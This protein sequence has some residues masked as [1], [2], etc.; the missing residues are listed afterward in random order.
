MNPTPVT[1]SSG[2]PAGE[3]TAG[4]KTGGKTVEKAKAGSARAKGSPGLVALVGTGPG[5]EDL[6]TVRAAAL[7]GQADLVVAEPAESERLAHLMGPDVT[8]ADAAELN[9]DQKMLVKAA[10]AGQ[11][12]VRLLRGDP[13]LF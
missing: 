11:L 3:M 10:R 13:F 9:E 7:L 1:G 8:V 12:V 4:E 5:T 2:R 6:L